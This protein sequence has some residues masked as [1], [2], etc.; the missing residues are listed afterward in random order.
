MGRS[1][2]CGCP[3][4]AL[5]GKGRVRCRE[6]RVAVGRQIDA[7]EGLVVQGV[8]ERQRDS[9]DLSSP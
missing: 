4:Q 5:V 3:R 7:G 2:S 8:G 9:G 1:C 6:L